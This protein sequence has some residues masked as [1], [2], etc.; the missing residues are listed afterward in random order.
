MLSHEIGKECYIITAL[1]KALGKS[2]TER[3]R[4]NNRRIDTILHRQFFQLPRNATR[5]N[6]LPILV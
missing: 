3:V 2:M 4:I 1:Q 6:T 5:C